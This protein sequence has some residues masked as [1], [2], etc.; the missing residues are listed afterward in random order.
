[1]ATEQSEFGLPT[2][3]D[4]S[5][6]SA[7]FLP[8]FFRSEANLKFLQATIDQLIQPGVAEKLSGYYGRKTAKGFKATDTYIPEYSANNV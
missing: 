3:D 1:M 6:K 2:P 8:R 4:D 5:R 7:R